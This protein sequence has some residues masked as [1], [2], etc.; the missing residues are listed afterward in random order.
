MKSNIFI[1]VPLLGLLCSAETFGNQAEGI[2]TAEW[3][4]AMRSA[5]ATGTTSIPGYNITAKYPGKRSDNWTLSISVASDIP[6]GNTANGQFVTGTQLEWTAPPGLISSADPSWFLCRTAYSSSKLK[7][8]GSGS[9]NG[10]CDGLLSDDCLSALQSSLTAGT[11]CQNNTLP[12]ICVDEL[13]LS[14]GE[15][16]GLTSGKPWS[17]RNFFQPAILCTNNA[18][19]HPI[20][21][22]DN[23]PVQILFGNES[24]ERGNF[25][26][27]DNA[28]R[29]GW[30]VITGFAEAGS[31]NAHPRGSAGQPGSVACIQANEIQNKSRDF[32]KAA[33]IVPLSLVQI[34][35]GIA[36]VVSLY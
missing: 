2:S 18:P 9:T 24:H 16:F 20:N 13:G 35:V 34:L 21:G 29:Q 10:S 1:S 11:Q 15:G 32:S 14:D 6:G 33:H 25:T 12:S 36:V 19:A 28:I 3:E 27:Y 26:A 30:L 22:T 7:H 8:D 23:T 4:L 31:D 17:A 5:N